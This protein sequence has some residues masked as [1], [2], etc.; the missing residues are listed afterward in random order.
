MTTSS[1]TSSLIKRHSPDCPA[2]GANSDG[3]NVAQSPN[4]NAGYGRV[5]VGQNSSITVSNG[6][7]VRVNLTSQSSYYNLA[8][9]GNN[10]TIKAGGAGSNNMN[11]VGY[12]VYA[13][14]RDNVLTNGTAMGTN[15]V[16]VIGSGATISTTGNNGYAV[17]A[18]KGGVVQLQGGSIETSG[19]GA[20][21]LRA[22]KKITSGNNDNSLGGRIEL[23]GSV[24]I[25][26]ADIAG[27]YA[28]H[29]LGD[30]SMIS[31]SRT[32][33]YTGTAEDKLYD[34]TGTIVNS[35]AKVTTATSGI[36]N[37]TGNMLA[38]SGMID[39]H[40][41]D[42]SLFTGATKRG[43]YTYKNAS[44]VS[45][46]DAR[47]VINLNIDGASSVWNMTASSELT[48]LTLN[49]STLNYL[50]PTVD[51]TLQSSYKTLTVYGNYVGTGGTIS[52][53]TYLG[54]DTSPSDRLVI[55]GA[56]A[57]ATGSTFLL[58][59][60]NGGGGAQ[61]TG[62]GI[63]LVQTM[64]GATTASGAFTL[65]G[66]VA[67]GAYDY[68]LYQGGSPATGGDPND[69]N[70]YLRSLDPP[71]P[72]PATP[73]DLAAAPAPW[74]PPA[75]PEVLVATAIQPLA[76]EYGYAMLDTLH[77]RVGETYIAPLAPVTEERFV[78]CRDASKNFRCMVRVP[79][80]NANRGSNDEPRWAKS[81]WARIL[82]NRGLHQPDNFG[83]RGPNY[84]YTFGG[85]QVGFDV[86][87]REQADSTL[88]KAGIYAGYGQITSDVSGPYGLN[89]RKVVGKAGSVDMDAY[90]LGAYWTHFSPRGWYTD[91]VVQGTWYSADAHSVLNQNVKPDGF[92]ILASLEGGYAFELGRGFKLEP[93]A[94]IVYQNVSFDSARDSYGLY[95]FDDGDSLRGRLGVRLAKTWNM[96]D[97]GCDQ[98]L[99]TV[100]LRANV[101]HEFMGKT[102][103]TVS[104]LNGSNPL[105]FNSYLA[106]TWGEVD[107]GVTAQMTDKI[108]L[109]ATGAFN[110]S[111]DNKGRE[112]WD[113]RLGMTVKW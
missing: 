61:T 10:A 89:G 13:G 73:P 33:Y 76:M 106:G 21:A 16:A 29:T 111:L 37:I 38:E 75:R 85:I 66:R 86:Y 70:W 27:A 17:Y 60:N 99:L 80:P 104:A 84:D 4:G 47:G 23:V 41:T 42:S 113:G 78:R 5:Y 46:T 31:S 9:I 103:T 88:D 96:A 108:N 67:A 11:T 28:I 53:H 40:M 68:F 105:P 7:A 87:A 71:S 26:V 92:G 74:T 45:I 98:R 1:Q 15:A 72:A 34:G 63:L 36:Y 32:N 25:S 44:N 65:A 2:T 3:V 12:A 82:G 18:N 102:T 97:Q 109:F 58:I 83:K 39:L 91:A 24:T 59:N 55:D 52:L 35:S 14:N 110:R 57:T 51:P 69:Q 6:T 95:R 112:G 93:Q 100:W 81:G 20:D 90:T 22:E 30:G 101:W 79:V 107:A 19:T 94:Q 62:D 49:G 54:D 48:N 56:T 8:Y 77:E 43:S 64:N 50:A